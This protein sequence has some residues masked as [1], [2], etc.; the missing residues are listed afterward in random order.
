MKVLQ[1]TPYFPPHKWWLETVAEEFSKYFVQQGWEVI[2]V[3][4]SIWQEH[5]NSYIRDGYKV[6]IVPSFDIIPNF[7]VPK[8]RKKEFWTVMKMIKKEKAD[9]VQTHTR[10]FLSTFLWWFLA[11]CRRIKRVHI[12]HGSEYVQVSAWRKNKIAYFYDRLIGK[13]VFKRADFI[14]PIS[15]AC[16]HFIEMKFLKRPNMQV[17]Y[18]WLE[19]PHILPKVEN[20]HEKFPDKYIVWFIG[21]LY[22]RKNVENMIT[23]YY[24][25]DKNIQNKLQ[26][27]IVG[28]GEDFKKLQALDIDKRV[29]FTWGKPFTEALAYQKQFDIH[30]HTSNPWWWL[31]TTLLQAM[32]FGCFIVATPNE[33][34]LDVLEN[35]KNA[36]VL[37]NSTLEEIIIWYKQWLDWYNKKLERA[38]IN[39]KIIEE[40]FDWKYNIK[41]YFILYKD[42][43]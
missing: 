21:R 13:W 17:V 5:E 28:D 9:I 38:K 39:E 31:A 22:K 29:Y 24:S 36:V 25:L 33:W 26:I 1:F 8:F 42:L 10:F 27:V 34:S 18:R 30:Y 40:K 16:K 32:Y 3:T 35:H 4:S 43:L 20:L 15:N 23:A 41:T 37:Q 6:I 7:P 19:I 11:R 12:E 14:I 2:N